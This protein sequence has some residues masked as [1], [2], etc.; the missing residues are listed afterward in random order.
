MLGRLNMQQGLAPVGGRPQLEPVVLPLEGRARAEGGLQ[1]DPVKLVE[2]GQQVA[3]VDIVFLCIEVLA[4]A[5]VAGQVTALCIAR[6]LCCIK[7][8]LAKI[9]L[10]RG[11]CC[12]VGR[13]LDTTQRCD[14]KNGT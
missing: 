10:K 5:V 6:L 1:A 2:I 13:W 7:A 4:A 11:I 9:E 3:I 12:G 14:S 8:Q